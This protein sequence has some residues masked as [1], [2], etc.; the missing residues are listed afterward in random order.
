MN[1]DDAARAAEALVP[2]GV[3]GGEFLRQTFPPPRP[4]IEGVLSDE[5]GGFRGGEEKLGKSIEV[6]DEIICLTFA[7]PSSGASRSRPRA[8]SS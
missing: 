4:L 3:G 2:L 8:A 6:L 5:G 7:R 1:L